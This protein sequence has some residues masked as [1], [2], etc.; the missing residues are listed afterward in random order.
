MKSREI[1]QDVI[2]GIIIIIF[3]AFFFYITRNLNLKS[4]MMPRLLL[5]ILTIL[6]GMVCFDGLKKTKNVVETG[7]MEKFITVKSLKIPMTAYLYIAS[8]VFLFKVAGYFIATPLFLIFLMRHFQEKSW[9]RI[10]LVTGIYLSI[11]YLVFVQQL[12]VSVDNFG[13]IGRYLNI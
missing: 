9:K 7:K 1:H 8:Y 6:G 12:N 10:I 5:T 3:C 2:I 13:V 11:I 4:G